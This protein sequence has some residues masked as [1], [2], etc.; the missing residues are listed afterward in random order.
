MKWMKIRSSWGD[1]VCLVIVLIDI[2]MWNR[3]KETANVPVT[4]FNHYFIIPLFMGFLSVSLSAYLFLVATTNT[5]AMIVFF[6][7][8]RIHNS[9]TYKGIHTLSKAYSLAHIK[10]QGTHPLWGPLFKV[11]ING[12][13]KV[14]MLFFSPFCSLPLNWI[15]TTLSSWPGKVICCHYL[16]IMIKQKSSVTVNMVFPQY[17]A[18]FPRLHST[19][20]CP[21]FLWHCVT[22]VL[23]FF[24]WEL[25]LSQIASL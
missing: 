2:Y 3:Q 7:V 19:L 24:C 22:S 4:I 14:T 8:M 1:L 10:V 25:N 6:M 5:H 18:L 23:F 11:S 12:R 20:Y 21:P 16:R 17:C 9:H 13:I 15:L